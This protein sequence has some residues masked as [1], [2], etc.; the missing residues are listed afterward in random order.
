[1]DRIPD[2]DLPPDPVIPFRPKATPG[3]IKAFD[4]RDD[5]LEIATLL[6]HLSPA[7]RVQYLA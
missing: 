3:Q 4:T 5:R 7:R 6:K 2:S 1:M